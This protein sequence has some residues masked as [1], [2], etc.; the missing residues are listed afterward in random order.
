MDDRQVRSSGSRSSVYDYFYFISGLPQVAFYVIGVVELVILVGFL[1]GVMKRFTYGAV[2][3]LHGVL[4]L[5]SFRQ[6]LIPFEDPSLLFFPAWP[7]LAACFTL[8]YLRDLDAMWTV[9]GGREIPARLNDSGALV[10]YR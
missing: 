7:M 10:S 6:Y 3:L 9:V 4:T 2:L 5:S 1:A 8:Y